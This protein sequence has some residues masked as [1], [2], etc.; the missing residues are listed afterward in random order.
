[1]YDLLLASLLDFVCLYIALLIVF[2]PHYI[3]ELSNLVTTFT[4]S[5]AMTSCWPEKT[6]WTF[7]IPIYYNKL[8]KDRYITS[9]TKIISTFH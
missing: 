3:N 7:N 9:K 2:K 6:F 8:K 5:E 1:M 4:S